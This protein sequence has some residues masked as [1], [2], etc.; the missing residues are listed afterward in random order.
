MVS[1]YAEAQGCPLISITAL[2]ERTRSADGREQ[3]ADTVKMA[4]RRLSDKTSLK[5]RI[6][7]TRMASIRSDERADR[8]GGNM[9]RFHYRF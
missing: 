6:L 2:A 8:N 5:R 9:V 3:A 7:T 4:M 1:A